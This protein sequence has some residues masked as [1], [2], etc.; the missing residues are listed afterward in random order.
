VTYYG[1]EATHSGM[2]KFE[3][4]N[5]PGYR[6]VSTALRE[7]VADAPQVIPIRWEVEEDDR[8]MRANLENMERA[9]LYQGSALAATA[10]QQQQ[11]QITT[12]TTTGRFLSSPA[13][14]VWYH[15]PWPLQGLLLRVVGDDDDAEHGPFHKTPSVADSDPYTRDAR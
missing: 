15:A 2:C 7:W 8:R 6:T 5:A 12:T 9:R 13:G 1:I 14:H 11:Q 4:E 10:A 3:S